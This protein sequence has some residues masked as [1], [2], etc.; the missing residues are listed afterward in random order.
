MA[1]STR[2]LMKI[3]MDV[4]ASTQYNLTSRLKDRGGSEGVKFTSAPFLVQHL[5]KLNE[6]LVA[7]V[8]RMMDGSLSL[9]TLRSKY[10]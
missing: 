7:V 8:M 9:T 3:S 2:N 4:L 1:N 10:L 6:Q 5:D